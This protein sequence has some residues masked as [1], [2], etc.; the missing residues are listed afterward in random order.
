MTVPEEG[1]VGD[2]TSLELSAPDHERVAPD[3]CSREGSAGSEGK[4]LPW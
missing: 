1:V 3:E 2:V 4:Q